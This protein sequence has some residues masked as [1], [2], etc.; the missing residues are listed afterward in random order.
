M[1]ATY[2]DSAQETLGSSELDDLITAALAGVD[3]SSQR[4][5]DVSSETVRQI[6]LVAPA[7]LEKSCQVCGKNVAGQLRYKDNNGYWCVDCHKSDV[8]NHGDGSDEG[9]VTQLSLEQNQTR[10]NKIAKREKERRM[11]CLQL[12]IVAAVIVWCVAGYRS[13]LLFGTTQSHSSGNDAHDLMEGGRVLGLSVLAMVSG[14][15][16]WIKRQV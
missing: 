12:L 1:L 9:P 15:V 13:G 2:S 10:L 7:A 14:V 11:I 4:S 8:Q 16:W 5:A 3:D 6:E